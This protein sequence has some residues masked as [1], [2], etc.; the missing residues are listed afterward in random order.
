MRG[1][2]LNIVIISLRFSPAFISHMKAYEKM[3]KI[4]GH[5]VVFFIDEKYREYDE[6]KYEDKC[7]SSLNGE[8]IKKYD[9]VLLIN[10]AVE[11]L[12]VVLW[13]CVYC[14]KII[15][16][17]HEP[18]ISMRRMKKE[19]WRN[20]IK[21][22][23]AAFCSY[24]TCKCS[25]KILFASKYACKQYMKN[26]KN[27]NDNLDIL[28]LMFCD[29]LGDD[30]DIR[31]KKYFSYIGTIAK[32][33]AFE[34]YLLLIKNLHKVEPQMNFLI[35]TKSDMSN[36][37][38]NDV[39][40]KKMQKDNILCIYHNIIMTNAEINRHYKK[41]FCVWN[42][43]S[44]GTQSGVLGKAFMAGTPVL[45]T[46]VGSFE[47]FVTCGENGEFVNNE[48]IEDMINKIMTIYTNI[49]SYS[50]S[51]RKAYE[52]IFD[53]EINANRLEKIIS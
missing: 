23:G 30:T 3:L 41:S 49:F 50:K 15:Y 37:L 34:N 16:I 19:G 43:Y 6:F 4:K 10:A 8:N 12:K 47:E 46:R 31:E 51:A 42:A 44:S 24:I 52:K 11:N 28:P 2:I 9:M 36:I 25:Y 13:S 33:H 45:A 38:D 20:A 35:A 7:I 48:D 53:C 21:L 22:I 5:D 29:E 40:L 27:V 26:F 32:G 17:F 39:D 1:E 18:D 14:K